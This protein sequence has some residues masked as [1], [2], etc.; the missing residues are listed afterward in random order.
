MCSLRLHFFPVQC[1]AV[2][3][4]SLSS[5]VSIRVCFVDIQVDVLRLFT[6]FHF[7]KEYTNAIQTEGR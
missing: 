3:A 5:A 1:P 7:I 6:I 2:W 4:P